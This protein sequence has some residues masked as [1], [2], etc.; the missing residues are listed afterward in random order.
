MKNLKSSKAKKIEIIR[1]Q[2]RVPRVGSFNI[3]DVS[4]EL[5]LNEL[6]I[7]AYGLGGDKFLFVRPCPIVPNHGGAV[8]GFQSQK[9]PVKD[10]FAHVA[11]MAMAIKKAG[12]DADIVV[13]PWLNAAYSG[14]GS[15]NGTI[16]LGRG[17]D[18][19]TAGGSETIVVPTIPGVPMWVNH[20]V[21]DPLKVEFEYVVDKSQDTYMVQAREAP[22]HISVGRAV[23]GAR[24]GFVPNGQMQIKNVYVVQSLDDLGELE[25]LKDNPEGLLIIQEKGSL[26]SHA[27]AHCRGAQITMVVDSPSNYAVGDYIT[28]I[29]P[30]WV[31]KGQYDA[32]PPYD[33][34]DY[35]KEFMAGTTQK[36]ATST[37]LILST[38]FHQWAT[39]PLGDPGQTA[40]LAGAF[41]R[42]LL[43]NAAAVCIG[44]ARHLKAKRND[45]AINNHA[46][47][48]MFKKMNIPMAPDSRDM[49]YYQFHGCH[50]PLAKIAKVLWTA[51]QIHSRGWISGFGGPKWA[52]GSRSGFRL[53]SALLEES[54]N[55]SDVIKY[56]NELENAVHNGGNLFN[57][58]SYAPTMLETGTAGFDLGVPSS[59]K[60]MI[61]YVATAAFKL[62]DGEGQIA[63]STNPSIDIII[64]TGESLEQTVDINDVPLWNKDEVQIAAQE[65]QKK[66]SEAAAAVYAK[67]PNDAPTKSWVF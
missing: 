56:A 16:V 19:V 3:E 42:S 38:F 8:G 12:V 47:R 66:Y 25:N 49:V 5:L 18:G 40:F 6:S 26:M 33:P 39:S 48:E 41:V 13:M 45:N 55:I 24:P 50:T 59:M 34:A 32:P 54:V 63:D 58:F 61:G 60:S 7:P 1:Q 43:N 29:S 30:G 37:G 64:Q 21:D 27:A 46:F 10:A 2:H 14:V 51:W 22:E 4:P 57:K 62:L 23:K 36:T 44:E 20:V 15:P 17:H 35:L 31:L 53:A 11:T 67:N 65:K 28:E 9:V 52:E